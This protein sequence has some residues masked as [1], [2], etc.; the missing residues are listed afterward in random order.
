MSGDRTS[1]SRDRGTP[2]GS[3]A[4]P[5]RPVVGRN[6]LV[7]LDPPYLITQAG[8]NCYWSTELELRL[9][10]YIDDLD[11]LGI[12][13]LMSNVSRHKGRE[14]PHLGRLRKYEMVELEHDYDRVSRSGGSQ[15]QE[16]AVKNY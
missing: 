4:L 13:F 14:N 9:Y 1:Q 11:R 5:S 10:D 12:R 6:V 15:T 3:G 8:Y 7:Y 2:L 16:I